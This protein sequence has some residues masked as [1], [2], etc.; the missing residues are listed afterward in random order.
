MLKVCAEAARRGLPIFLYGSRPEVL[1]ALQRRLGDLFP[2]LQIAGAEPSKFRTISSLERQQSV[3]RIRSSGA[4]LIFVGLGCPRQEVWAYE[5]RELLA[6]PILAVGAA[7]DFHAGFIRPAPRRL[8]DA[9]L[10]W[11][12][13][14]GQEPRRLWRR[15]VYLNPLFMGHLVLQATRLK[16]YDPGDTL[17]PVDEVGYG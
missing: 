13:R 11:L 2:S 10:E 9:G 4:K 1:A 5:Y 14:L 7:F 15:Y 16:R 6:I 3:E 17:P 8:Q 12:Y